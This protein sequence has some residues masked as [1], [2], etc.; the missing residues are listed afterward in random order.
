MSTVHCPLSTVVAPYNAP[1][2]TPPVRSSY[3]AARRVG[4]AA[5]AQLLREK[6]SEHEAEIIRNEALAAA[7]ESGHRLVIDLSE[8]RLLT[9]SGIG[10][11]IMIDRE[12]RTKSGKMA[13]TGLT[14]EL[15]GLL[16][17]TKLDRVFTIKKDQAEAVIAVS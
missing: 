8:V 11:L 5:V 2:S 16:K 6:I 1:V 13:L 14:D 3:V 17:M 9:S 7:A 15:L 10:A 12:C 4:K